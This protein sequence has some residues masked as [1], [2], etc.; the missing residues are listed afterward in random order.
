MENGAEAGSDAVEMARG[1]LVTYTGDDTDAVMA[2]SNVADPSIAPDL[3]SQPLTD[4]GVSVV[5]QDV[6]E[7]NVAAQVQSHITRAKL[8]LMQP[9]QKERMNWIKGD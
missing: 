4:W 1:T 3:D 7:R 6:L 5:D 2:D 9:C 8:R